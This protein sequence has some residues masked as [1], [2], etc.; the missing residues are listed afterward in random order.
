MT[1]PT[2][3][4]PRQVTLA[5]WLIMVGSAIVVALVY[6]CVSG[7]HTVETRETVEAFIAKPPISELDIGVDAV[8]TAIRMMAMVTAGCATAA[9]ILGYQVLRR[10]RSARLALTVL[11]VPLFLAGLVT[12]GFLTSV[13]AAA[14]V[15]LWLQPARSWFDGTAPPP[16][17]TTPPAARAP[18]AAALPERRPAAPVHQPVQQP[19]QQPTQQPIRPPVQRPEGSGFARRPAVVTW[20]CMLTWIGTGVTVLAM[21]GSAVLLAIEPDRML[22]EVHRENPD[23]A[24]QG[25]SDDLLLTVTYLMIVGIIVWCVAAAVLA[26]LVFRGLEWAR[27]VLIVSACVAG[28]ICLLGVVVGAVVLAAPLIVSV[29][30]VAL[31]LR[32]EARPWF[33]RRDRRT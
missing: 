33:A 30:S 18:H 8:I 3:E 21:I 29:L 14:A 4:R 19:V 7:L 17:R 23:L 32:A 26:V 25:I 20:A 24:G 1:E 11:A 13:V 16:S 12:G 27:I 10:S 22:D 2:P 6:Q 15:I 9:A 5:G 28:A 31:L